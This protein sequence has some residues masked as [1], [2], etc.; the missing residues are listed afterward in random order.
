M[1]AASLCWK[2]LISSSAWA[3]SMRNGVYMAIPYLRLARR[4]AGMP[5]R[6]V[7]PTLLAD[8]VAAAA[9]ILTFDP[10][11]PDDFA[12]NF[13]A[14]RE[15]FAGDRLRAAGAAAGGLFAVAFV[16]VAFVAVVF[17]AVAFFATTL[18]PV[19]FATA[20]D[21]VAASGATARAEMPAAASCFFSADTSARNAARSSPAPPWLAARC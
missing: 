10:A 20:A 19:D 6:T 17:F 12:T 8:A 4:G 16:A 9:L 13:A 11:L 2:R 15:A 3:G 5:G 18:R 21:R 7:A 14:G 1:P